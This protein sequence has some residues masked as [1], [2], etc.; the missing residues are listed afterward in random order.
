MLGNYYLSTSCCDSAVVGLWERSD[1][2]GEF[3]DY[4]RLSS[5]PAGYQRV[6]NNE[7]SVYLDLQ[8]CKKC[9]PEGDTY[10]L[11]PNTDQCQTC[12]PGLTCFGNETVVPKVPNSM[13]TSAGQRD[14]T[15]G[16]Y[17]LTFCPPHHRIVNYTSASARELSSPSLRSQAK[18]VLECVTCLKGTECSDPP[19]LECTPCRPGFYK[20]TD[21]AE[22]CLPCPINTYNPAWGANVLQG[23]LNCPDG[24]ATEDRTGRISVSE[25]KCASHLYRIELN[26]SDL[27]QCQACPIGAICKDRSCALHGESLN[28]TSQAGGRIPG[29]WSRQPLSSGDNHYTLTSCPP[30]TEL[31]SE[32]E[33]GSPDLQQCKPCTAGTE[34][35]IDPD[36]DVCEKCPPGLQRL[37]FLVCLA[38]IFD[39]V[40]VYEQA[41]TVC[42]SVQAQHL[43]FP[44]SSSRFPQ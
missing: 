35:I 39:I 20:A 28:C 13:W 34:Y 24:S 31:Q 7:S 22:A 32:E 11:D 6:S 37:R 4:F 16:F 17:W 29:N 41:W 19:C 23:C 26:V 42:K 5:C 18:S 21:G 3:G 9:V 14:G 43:R 27:P 25:C 44:T 10:I 15:G 36:R 40:F 2:R 1:A 30:G 12:P 38:G 8:V 33:M